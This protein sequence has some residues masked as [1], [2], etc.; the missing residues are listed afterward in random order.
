LLEHVGGHF[1]AL[2]CFVA[3]LNHLLHVLEVGVQLLAIF[4]G[5]LVRP[6]FKELEAMLVLIVVEVLESCQEVGPELLFVAGVL[7]PWVDQVSEDLTIPVQNLRVFESQVWISQVVSV[8]HKPIG[9]HFRDRGL[10]PNVDTLLFNVVVGGEHGNVIG[11][12]Q[13]VHDEREFVLLILQ[14]FQ[15]VL[16][17]LWHQ[18]WGLQESLDL[19]DVF[20]ES[21]FAFFVVRNHR[22][23]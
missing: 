11:L 2:A 13:R 18:V 3:I 9:K 5:K 23:C 22:V 21:R 15:H 7:E 16:L 20:F 8:V 6:R 4:I 17:A 14:S 10:M 12:R 1:A 19:S